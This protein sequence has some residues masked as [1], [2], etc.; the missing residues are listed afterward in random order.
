MVV[1]T[2][3]L[4]LK[5]IGKSLEESCSEALSVCIGTSAIARSMI[6]SSSLPL[7][8]SDLRDMIVNSGSAKAKRFLA[9]AF[10]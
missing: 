8:L 2:K 6:Q 4:T 7:G 1:L 3:C 5:G 9:D 10:D